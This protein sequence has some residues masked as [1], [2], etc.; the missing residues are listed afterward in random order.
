MYI[1][2]MTK[3]LLETVRQAVPIEVSDVKRVQAIGDDLEWSN[4][5]VLRL[6]IKVGLKHYRKGQR[7]P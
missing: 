3:Q 2:G 5:K 7:K 6:L 4:A 1:P